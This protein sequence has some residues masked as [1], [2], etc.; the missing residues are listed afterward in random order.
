MLAEQWAG[1]EPPPSGVRRSPAEVPPRRRRG[2]RLGAP[3]GGRC[4]AVPS[5]R[6]G[7]WP[8]EGEGIGAGLLWRCRPSAAKRRASGCR[9]GLREVC[10]CS[11]FGASGVNSEVPSRCVAKV[12]SNPNRSAKRGVSLPDLTAL[13]RGGSDFKDSKS[14]CSAG[15]LRTWLS[16]SPCCTV[17]RLE[18][19]L[20]A[21]G[22][23]CCKEVA[24]S[25]RGVA[26]REELGPVQR[27]LKAGNVKGYFATYLRAS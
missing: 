14:G 5:G 8:R 9:S 27:S 12:P 21:Y 15:Q 20:E 13:A 19:R 3:P 10:R 24:A 7:G 6:A 23:R 17:R 18:G 4:H 22:G 25:V 2:G 26:P 16:E 11:N 1:N